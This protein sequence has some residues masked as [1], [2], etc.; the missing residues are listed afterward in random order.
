MGDEA[1]SPPCPTDQEFTDEQVTKSLLF[2]AAYVNAFVSI[3]ASADAVSRSWHRRRFTFQ[4][5]EKLAIYP[6]YNQG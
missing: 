2:S 4:A 6:L 3:V 1:V 5:R